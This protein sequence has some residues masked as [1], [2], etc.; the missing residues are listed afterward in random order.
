MK[1]QGKQLND[2]LS[3]HCHQMM[4]EEQSF[5][6]WQMGPFWTSTTVNHIHQPCWSP[7][8]SSRTAQVP[9]TDTVRETHEGHDLSHVLGIP[10]GH[11]LSR[12]SEALRHSTEGQL[13]RANT[14]AILPIGSIPVS[15]S[16]DT[17]DDTKS[18]A[19]GGNLG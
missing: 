3:P 2:V 10:S 17:W 9:C 13:S 7:V 5:N 12:D 11:T 6:A 18:M 4:K 14:V 1:L 15:G 8:N 19:V 16:P